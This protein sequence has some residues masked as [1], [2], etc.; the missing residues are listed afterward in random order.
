M[1]RALLSYRKLNDADLLRLAVEHLQTVRDLDF[2]RR[3]ALD[4]IL[5][6]SNIHAV[7]VAFIV[8]LL[9]ESLPPLDVREALTS[10]SSRDLEYLSD[11]FDEKNDPSGLTIR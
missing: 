11:T 6:G 10:T 3:T 1:H 9:E 2:D 4:I 5:Q 7:P 8:L